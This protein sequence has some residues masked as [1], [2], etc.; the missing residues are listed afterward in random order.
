MREGVTALR[1]YLVHQRVF[2]LAGKVMLR[3]S[4]SLF[5]AFGVVPVHFF[6]AHELSHHLLSHSTENGH[7]RQR[8]LDADSLAAEIVKSL[9]R[10]GPKGEAETMKACWEAL[11]SLE[12]YSRGVF[13][14]GPQSHPSLEDRWKVVR[15]R[16]NVSGSFYPAGAGGLLDIV[17]AAAETDMPIG[18]R[19]WVSFQESS[20][21]DTSYHDRPYFEWIRGLDMASGFGYDRACELVVEMIG[22]GYAVEGL[23]YLR[24]GDL[25]GALTRWRTTDLASELDGPGALTHYRM[26]ESFTHALLQDVTNSAFRSSVAAILAAQLARYLKDN[27]M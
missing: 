26:V 13:V 5:D 25:A 6:I 10:A 17:E 22:P 16:F 23:R 7:D 27:N 4:P 20:R 19:N 3:K 14:R 2:G 21:W 11:V 24:D 9:G 1:Y 12:L 18:E 8:E 15:A